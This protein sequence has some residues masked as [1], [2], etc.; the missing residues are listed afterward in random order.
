MDGPISITEVTVKNILTRAERGFLRNKDGNRP[1][2]SHSLQPY[3]GCT[4]GNSLCGVGCYVRANF[5][6]TKGRP[7][8]GYLDVRTNAA[9]SY[10]QNFDKERRW[11]KNEVGRFSIFCSSSTDPFVPQELRYGIT[12]SILEAMTTSP[13]DVLILQ[14]H[15]HLVTRYMDLYAVLAKSCDLRFHVSIETDREVMSDLPPHASP[16]AKRF[17]ACDELRRAGHFTV[18]MVAPLLPIADPDTFFRRVSEVA[19][20]VVLDHYI[21]GDGTPDGRWTAKTRL[22]SAMAIYDPDSLQLGYRDKMVE[23]AR[24]HMPGR[25]GVSADGFAGV[26]A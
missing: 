14:T 16:I 23:R 25:V 15:S 5:H 4:Y 22:P 19:D 12:R 21:I 13:P 8:G 17:D 18:V 3:S 11:A 24:R 10:L 6:V 1:V 2:C 20:A 26:Y 7:W 9:A